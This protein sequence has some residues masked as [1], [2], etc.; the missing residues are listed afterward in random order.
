MLVR[1]RSG[2]MMAVELKTGFGEY[3]T[4]CSGHMET[5]LRAVTDSPLHQAVLQAAMG[6][7]LAKRRYPE[8]G[9]TDGAVVRVLGDDVRVY[10]LGRFP[11]LP[12]AVKA[13]RQMIRIPRARD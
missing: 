10:T 9:D 12:A 11:W 3:F 13:I 8:L 7:Q 1:T 4:H 5:P 6:I 2:Q